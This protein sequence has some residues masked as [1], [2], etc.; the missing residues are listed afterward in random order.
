[1][2]SQHESGEVELH[3]VRYTVSEYGNVQSKLCIYKKKSK[4]IGEA[5]K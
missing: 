3:S 2:V 4:S 5:D 1:M